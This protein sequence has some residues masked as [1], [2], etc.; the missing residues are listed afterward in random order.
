VLHRTLEDK[1]RKEFEDGVDALEEV[2]LAGVG[3]A[4]AAEDPEEVHLA[5][6]GEETEREVAFGPMIKGPL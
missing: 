3:E 2:P 5:E 1:R 4:G 6:D